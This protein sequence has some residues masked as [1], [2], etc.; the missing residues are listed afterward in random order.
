MKRY[1]KSDPVQRAEVIIG[2]PLHRQVLY[3]L[4]DISLPPLLSRNIGTTINDSTAK[5]PTKALGSAKLI[6]ESIFKGCMILR[7]LN[8]VIILHIAMQTLNSAP[9]TR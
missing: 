5:I 4:S 2:R 3:H 8:K 9:G 1:K 6:N 7:T